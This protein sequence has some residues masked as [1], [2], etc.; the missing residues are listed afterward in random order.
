MSQNNLELSAQIEILRNK[1][2]EFIKK[3][4]K[5]QLLKGSFY[6]GIILVSFL[7]FTSVLEYFGRF[8]TD[9]RT[10]LLSLLI[11]V[12]AGVAIRYFFIPLAR[13]YRI[14]KT[15]SYEEAS[16]ILGS[17]F[18]EVQDKLINVLQ[19]N[20]ISE[21]QNELLIAS[22][23]QKV[24]EIKPIPFLSAIK[25]KENLKYAKYFALVF[26]SFSF[27]WFA[28]PEV[29]KES[30]NRIIHPQTTFSRYHFIV[31]NNDLKVQQNEDFTLLVK[32]DGKVVPEEVFVELKDGRIKMK[33]M[34]RIHFSYTFKNVN[35]D[36][37]FE[38]KTDEVSSDAMLLKAL[39]KAVIE[40]MMVRLDYPAYLKK[41]P[42]TIKNNGDL[43]IPEGTKVSWEFKTK[44]ADQLLV[45]FNDSIVKPEAVNGLF[46]LQ[47]KIFSS[48][49]YQL[50]I[51]NKHF[52]DKNGPSYFINVQKDAFPEIKTQSI[53]DSVSLTK[54]YSMGLLADDYGL[55]RLTFNYK[56]VKEKGEKEESFVSKALNVNPALLEQKFNHFFDLNT[57]NAR[58]GEE[59]EYYFE[60]WDNDAVNG[61][62]S[63][64]ST[65]SSLR[66]PTEQELEDVM[67]SKQNE[68]S[69]KLKEANKEADLL[70][71]KYNEIHK[72]LISKKN[73]DWSDKKKIK[74]FLQ[75]QNDFA[76][77]IDD[78]K[79]ENSALNE[80]KEEFM[81]PSPELKKK[82]EQL[83]DLMD[84]LLPQ[85]MKEQ[86]KEL[87]K[88]LDELSKEKTEDLL[89]KINM[90][91]KD[92]EKELDRSLE[93]F[94][95]LEFEEKLD[96]TI[97]QLEKLANDEKKLSDQTKDAN[98]NEKDQLKEKQDQLNKQF[99]D[100][101]KDINELKDKNSKMEFPRE[102]KSPEQKQ[103]EAQEQMNKAN[104]N[105]E[106]NK[107]KNASENQKNASEKMEEMS[108]ELQAMKKKAEEKQDAE[109]MNSLRQILENLLYLSFEQE[110]L[111]VQFKQVSS[112]DPLYVQLSK[113]QHVLKS[114]AHVIEDS[115]L[116]LSKRQ[117][118][119]SSVINKEIGLINE[120][121][122][123]TVDLLSERQ[124]N[125]ANEKQRYVM[126]S[127]N[128][129][130]LILDESLQQMQKQMADKKFGTQQCN[131]PGQGQ[132]NM[133]DLKELQEKLNKQLQEMKN[134][135]DEGGKSGNKG[136]NGESGD[137]KKL[138]KMAAQQ[139]AVRQYMQEMN[140]QLNKEGKGGV[141][142]MEKL[143]ELMK[144]NEEDIVN[145]K[146]SG[147]TIK[148]QKEILTRL[149]EAEKAMREREF[150]KERKANEGKDSG[151]GNHNKDIEYK[152]LKNEEEELLKTV[153][154]T[155]NLFYKKKVNE[156][157]NT[158]NDN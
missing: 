1:L 83:Q 85:E 94:K 122:Q 148:R 99:E 12:S 154:P 90:N 11:T 79:K 114:D 77:K 43:F 22:I 58:P 51:T 47:K 115:L 139:A 54:L 6:A 49:K 46:S 25:L 33:K 26:L 81:E 38:V 20:Q 75:E 135:Q 110:K 116:A 95:Q 157:F 45:L 84:K 14:G 61:K 133:S 32:I 59:I 98:K 23:N 71:K 48:S 10:V 78:L 152:W 130:A 132:P 92:A 17:H 87:E 144:K 140:K 24:N 134:G 123:Q 70:Q 82:Q 151:N 29:V 137:K 155:L 28:F 67:Q 74:E 141:G 113:K 40:G 86:F 73:L 108:K 147:E 35:N 56:K 15:M 19:L 50:K 41:A 5:N 18:S 72:E 153:P 96:N 57:I 69:S 53:Q 36:I 34:D 106:N 145:N 102:F 4:Y 66:I 30:A 97:K 128:N 149:L 158:P 124:T 107:N 150:D 55:T 60:V 129:L 136:S 9:V 64:R 76:K 39:P 156:Y 121:L 101:K 126:I 37:D 112:K 52:S 118:Q 7:F 65:I 100:I 105:L 62:K 125:D 103:N 142:E 13:L 127:A 120:N 143:N 104:E 117:P 31:E 68:I 138:A 63:T 89:E 146:I 88:L 119:L 42:E 111:I 2:D 109:D 27:T 21:Q 93:I 91:N 131:K 44:N 80:K 3:Y 8:S 16:K